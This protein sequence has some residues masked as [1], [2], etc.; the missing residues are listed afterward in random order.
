M[1]VTVGVIAVGGRGTRLGKSEIQ[2][3]L[4]PVGGRPILEY[5]IDAFVANGVRLIILLTGF[6]HEQIDSYLA[7]S[8]Q[9]VDYILA[10]VYGGTIGEAPA[11][12]QLKPW[13]D[14]DFLYAGGDVVFE[15]GLVTQLLEDSK[16]HQGSAAIMSVNSYPSV[17]PTHPAVTV[18][19]TTN[20]VLAVFQTESDRHSA[21]QLVSTGMY[22]FRPT[23]FPFLGRVYPDRPMGEFISFALAERVEIVASA[24]ARPW[25]CLHTQDDLSKWL[26]SPLSC[27]R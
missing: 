8:R 25:F 12:Y 3:C 19:P 5:T 21:S 11:I 26:D 7:N 1:A 10:N 23:A 20:K 13:L 14:Q 15:S 18:A 9:E 4:T 22:Y 24:S 2:K 16:E 27:R 17:A 6:L